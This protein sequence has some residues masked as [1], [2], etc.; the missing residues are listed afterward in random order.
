MAELVE[1]DLALI[2]RKS[3]SKILLK[4]GSRFFAGGV[5]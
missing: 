5:L 2:S 1:K 3:E 4:K